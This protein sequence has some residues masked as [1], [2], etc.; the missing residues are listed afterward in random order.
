MLVGLKIFAGGGAGTLGLQPFAILYW[1]APYKQT[2]GGADVI[3]GSRSLPLGVAQ[4]DAAGWVFIVGLVVWWVLMQTPR[5]L[6]L[7]ALGVRGTRTD[8]AAWLLGGMIAA[9]AGGAW[10]LW[11]PSASEVYFYLCA[12]PF[13][14]AL[15]TW[16]LAERART[17][18]PV[19][20]GVL[21][22]GLW[23]VLAPH[24]DLPADPHSRHA[25]VWALATPVLRTVAV[26]AVVGT[27]GLLIW[28][29][30]TGRYAWRAVPVAVIAAVLGAA[31]AGSVNLQ[32]RQ[33]VETYQGKAA[34][35]GPP[36]REILEPEMRA[37]LW[38]DDHAGRDDVVATNVHCQPL[39]WRA[40][41][42][43]RAFWVAGL[44]GRRTLVE[45]WAYA[46]QT[47]AADGVNGRR[48]V[49]QPAPH[50]DRFALNQRVFATADP[51]DVARLRD[52]YHVRW[53]FADSRA[54]G[55]VA[56]GLA[57]VATLRYTAGPVTVYRLP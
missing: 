1:V 10:L 35:A 6:G 34:P 31:L 22:G 11:H 8:P 24:T 48:Y 53:L 45:S 57:K 44:G 54:V 16:L 7:V 47:V 41:C 43:S 55:G 51:A 12:V 40:A 32:V 4:A 26:A 25:W 33:T 21:A 23:A 14:T 49:L 19:V 2:L 15:T 37:A 5:V 20:A 36:G 9:G 29:L 3:D 52:E 46:D 27:L 50:P 39:A 18:R 56:P 42:D 17:W 38:L 13:G 28:R 30:T